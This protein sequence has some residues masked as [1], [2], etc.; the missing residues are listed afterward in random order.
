MLC[1]AVQ[2]LILGWAVSE[3]DLEVITKVVEQLC[4]ATRAEG[5]ATVVVLT[6]REKLEMEELFRWG[7]DGGVPLGCEA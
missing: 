1:C 6:Q 2:F 7:L 3:S 4:C 5:G